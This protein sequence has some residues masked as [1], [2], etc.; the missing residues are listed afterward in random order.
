MSS[1]L[2]TIHWLVCALSRAPGTLP[3]S[4]THCTPTST[5]TQPP[6]CR[7]PPAEMPPKQRPCRPARL[8]AFGRT[9]LDESSPPGSPPGCSGSGWCHT[10][11]NHRPLCS[12]GAFFSADFT[13]TAI[14]SV[15]VGGWLRL[16]QAQ[17]SDFL[18]VSCH[19]ML[20]VMVRTCF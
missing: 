6:C 13:C 5:P 11:R 9:F 19:L 18:L 8:P 1:S 2:S 16:L 4:P 10:C 15:C 7:P 3:C 14:E 17:F 12:R 20:I